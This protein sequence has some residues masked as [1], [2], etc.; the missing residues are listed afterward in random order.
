MN[1]NTALWVSGCLNVV[2]AGC[3]ILTAAGAISIPGPS[4]ATAFAASAGQGLKIEQALHTAGLGD[5]DSKRMVEALILQADTRSTSYEYWVSPQVRELRGQIENLERSARARATLVEMFGPSAKN[6]PAFANSFRPYHREFPMLT[7][8]QQVQL[9]EYNLQR[10]KAQLEGAAAGMMRVRANT[11]EDLLDQ[12]LKPDERFEYLL[13]ESVLA[14]ALS[15][16][17]FEFTEPEFRSVFG[18][19]A[20]TSP[21]MVMGV[22]PVTL[23]EA[24][25]SEANQKAIVE[26]IGRERYDALRRARDPSYN[27]LRRIAQARGIP[28]DKIEQAYTL[29]ANSKPPQGDPAAA[30]PPAELA[31]LLGAQPANEVFRA[32][33][34]S[35]QQSGAGRGLAQATSHLSGMPIQATP[36][37]PQ[38]LSNQ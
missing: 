38:T 25:T 12:L 24:L 7:P 21:E 15:S 37:N 28:A 19:L 10:L 32:F 16:S 18:I 2:F 5:V 36:L 29:L 3:L 20:K 11:A 22:N 23:N 9:Q 8:N 1:K 13:R 34:Y 14:K 27:L 33:Q 6:D 31:S 4:K 17:S 26:S 30:K 35:R